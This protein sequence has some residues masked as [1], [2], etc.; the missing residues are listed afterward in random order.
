MIWL[1]LEK[2]PRGRRGSPGKGV[3][4]EKRREGS[5]PSFSVALKKNSCCTYTRARV[6]LPPS[7]FNPF[8]IIWMEMYLD[9]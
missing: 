2:Y 6:Q 5:T 3:G 7:P 4:R 8:H 1:N 9:K